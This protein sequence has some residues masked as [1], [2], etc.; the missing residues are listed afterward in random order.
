MTSHTQPPDCAA[1]LARLK[2]DRESV[3]WHERGLLAQRLGAQ[4]GRE[5]IDAATEG[6][7]LFLADDPKWEVRK[8]VADCLSLLA[9]DAF[10]RVAAKLSGDSNTFVRQAVERALD[11]RRR[12]QETVRRKRRGLDHVQDEYADLQR[13]YGAIAADKA[14]RLAER[15]Y[16]VL[17]GSTVHDMR[18]LIGPLKS[19]LKTLRDQ[20]AAGTA[21]AVACT[22]RVAQMERQVA[23]IERLV[24]DMRTYA[25]PTPAERH[26]ER[27]A[28]LLEEAHGLALDALRASS[29]APS[30]IVVS[31][32]IPPSLTV[33]VARHQVVRALANVLKNAYESFATS[34]DSF[35]AG[36]VRVEA[37]AI[38]GERVEI[39]ICDNG[40]GLSPE[41]LADVRRFVPGG[42]S[43]KRYGTGF[44]LAIAKR[45]IDDHGGGLAID[46]QEDVGTT[47]TITL[48]VNVAGGEE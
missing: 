13:S 28:A 22:E 21:D 48:P 25:Q 8:E 9:D 30:G 27:V 6:L 33:T 2:Q 3:P 47:V 41:E 10:P 19:G 4:V 17:V 38:A 46:S 29:R 43:K 40:M 35:R 11:R 15:L 31:F 39:I 36:Q 45:K 1:V 42:T 32:A 44:G 5:E 14:Q 7:L 16:D 37:N 34:A 26:R 24:E 12:G 18:G 20:L 23:M